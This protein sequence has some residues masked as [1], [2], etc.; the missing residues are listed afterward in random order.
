[1]SHTAGCRARLSDAKPEPAHVD[2]PEPFAV[3]VTAPV[4]WRMRWTMGS[5]AAAMVMSVEAM[6]ME[7]SSVA[8]SVRGPARAALDSGAED[9][10]GADSSERDQADAPE[11]L[12]LSMPA[13]ASATAW[14]E[15][16]PSAAAQPQ[17]WMASLWRRSSTLWWSM[18][19]LCSR[20]PCPR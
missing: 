4:C 18:S 8:S 3:P 6:S 16:K 13:A 12:S 20:N 11:A 7:V 2:A 9:R 10:R 1:M 5:T 14:W 19:R 17:G 15:T